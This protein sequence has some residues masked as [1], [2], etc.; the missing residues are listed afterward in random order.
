MN[1][2]HA[3]RLADLFSRRLHG[4]MFLR[5]GETAKPDDADDAQYQR[6]ERLIGAMVNARPECL[7]KLN[8]DGT[9]FWSGAA[10]EV[11]F[12]LRNSKFRPTWLELDGAIRKAFNLK[13]PVELSGAD[14]AA[15]TVYTAPPPQPVAE[16]PAGQ[17]DGTYRPP[18]LDDYRRLVSRDK[19]GPFDVQMIGILSKMSDDGAFACIRKMHAENL[20]KAAR[21]AEAVQAGAQKA[22]AARQGKGGRDAVEMAARELRQLNL[23]DLVGTAAM[24]KPK[25]H[26]EE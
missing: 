16:L 21:K 14:A 8:P 9:P 18:W 2:L 19:G 15:R 4:E 12:F 20:E 26:W 11:I 7:G 6:I 10:W 23:I 5:P 24:P 3:V 25:D 1:H 13:K 17:A 22:D